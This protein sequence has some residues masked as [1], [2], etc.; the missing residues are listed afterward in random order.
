MNGGPPP[1]LMSTEVSVTNA[2]LHVRLIAKLL[3]LVFMCGVTRAQGADSYTIGPAPAWVIA[4]ATSPTNAP[5]KAET[6]QSIRLFDQQVNVAEKAHYRAYVREIHNESGVQDG[7]RINMYFDPTYQK[8]T[9]HQI[10]IRRGTNVLERLDREKI[11]VIQQERD[12]E[13]HIYDGT[14]SV[15]LFLDDVRVGDLLEYAFTVHGANPIFGERYATAFNTQWSIPVHSHRFRLLWPRARTLAHASY[16]RDLQPAIRDL[17]DVKEYV[18]QDWNVPAFLHEDEV[19]SWFYDYP[20][21]QLSEFGG[22]GDVARWAATL[23]PRPSALSDELKQKIAAWKQP[24]LSPADQVTAALNFVQQEVRYLGFEFGANSHRPSDPSTV[25]SRRFGDCKDKAYLLCAILTELGIEAAPALVNTDY[26]GRIQEWLPAPQ[27]FDHVITQVKAAGTTLYLDPTISHQGGPATER[28]LPD[29]QACLLVQKDATQLTTIPTPAR[30]R[31][32]TTISEEFVVRATNQPAQ[33][34]ITTVYS[35]AAADRVR[36]SFQESSRSEMEKEYLN[37]YG[38]QYPQIKPSRALET[39]DDPSRNVFTT[40][41]WYEIPGF[42]TLSEDQ[43][44]YTAEFYP[45]Y[46]GDQIYKPTTQLRSMPLAIEHPRRIIQRTTVALPEPWPTDKGQQTIPSKA[47]ILREKH[48]CN[49]SNLVMEYE[50]E[51]TTN[52]IATRDVPEYLKDIDRMEDALGYSLTWQN[53]FGPGGQVNWSMLLAGSMFGVLAS[54]GAVAVYRV[55]IKTPPVICEPSFTDQ[56][57]VGI[58]GWLILVAL[59]LI[60]SLVRVVINFVST[61]SVYSVESWA[62]VTTLG[63]ETYHVLWGPYLC[64]ALLANIALLILL[65]LMIV[66]FFRRRRIFPRVYIGYLV[67]AAIVTVIDVI[68]AQTLPMADVKSDAVRDLVQVVI[69]CGIWIPYMLVS[70]RVR[71]TFVR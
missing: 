14:V 54:V 6:G 21:V 1:A 65:I 53:A 20:W 61:W 43:R 28:Y 13:R 34:N 29:Y 58:A 24:G 49:E 66:L 33:F 15:L 47:A 64:W 40:K 67:F 12:L 26:Y 63:N 48:S 71:F 56:Q 23:Y 8:L 70:R 31:P 2:V 41:E 3:V 11:K 68:A 55:K 52:A 5:H 9:V 36:N 19:P 10:A 16:G 60:A 22:W 57:L 30:G 25:C 39:N 32:L 46:V 18:W 27:A 7:S 51:T 69:A 62:A 50:F 38:K 42:W 37:Y 17:A 44:T 59:G 35:G 4:P 45:A